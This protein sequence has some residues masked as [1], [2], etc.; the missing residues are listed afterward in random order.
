M[1]AYTG[2]V[3]FAR[4]PGEWHRVR[5]GDTDSVDSAVE[6]VLR[7][8]TP[9]M[10]FARTA[11][12]DVRIG[13]ETARAG[14]VV[15][16][17]NTSANFDERHFAD[18]DRFDVTRSPNDHLTFGQ[19][20]HYCIGAVMARIELRCLFAEMRDRVAEIELV[21]EPRQVYSNFLFGYS[22]APLRLVPAP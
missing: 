14:D 10:H 6:E 16:L 11:T 3:L 5:S 18:P 22:G 1:S 21:S 4:N 20:R 2:T 13:D 12:A 8:S 19:G 7:W 15:T 9:S 17:W